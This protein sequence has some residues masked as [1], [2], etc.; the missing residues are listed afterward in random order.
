MVTQVESQLTDLFIPNLI[1]KL[2]D[3]KIPLLGFT[4]IDTSV[5]PGIGFIPIWRAKELKRLG[6]NFHPI[7]SSFPK[8]NIEFTEF[9]SFR[10]TFPL[11]KDGIL[12]SNVTASKG[13][14]IKAFLNK[15]EKIPSRIIFID[16]SLENLQSV[17]LE[18][19]NLGIPYLGIHYRVQVDPTKLPK[20]TDNEWRCVW[21]KIH[22]RANSITSKDH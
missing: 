14:V 5:I 18:L 12:Y 4:A 17:E 3:Q 7:T 21:D 22:E 13:S 1:Q 19:Q 10:G 2:Q 16:D 9:S 6:I 11:Y 8:E 15:I 20:V